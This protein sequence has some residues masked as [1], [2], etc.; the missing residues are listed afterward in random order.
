MDCG[1]FVQTV[2]IYAAPIWQKALN[3]AE[4]ARSLKSSLGA[5]TAASIGILR[6]GA[7]TVSS[8]DQ[9]LTQAIEKAVP[10][11]CVTTVLQGQLSV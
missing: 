10:G 5:V 4:V 1:V 9:V 8:S 11:K 7:S 3:D 2:G 6:A